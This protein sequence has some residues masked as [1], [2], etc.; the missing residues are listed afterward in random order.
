MRFNPLSGEFEIAS[1]GGG[2]STFNP[3]SILTGYNGAGDL[4]VLIDEFGN[5]LTS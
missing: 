3:D 5:V 1:P 2:G 4:E